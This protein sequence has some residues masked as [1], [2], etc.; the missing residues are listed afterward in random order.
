MRWNEEHSLAGLPASSFI[1]RT[2]CSQR[3]APNEAPMASMARHMTVL[4]CANAQEEEEEEESVNLTE[5][6]DLSSRASREDVLRLYPKA[7]AVNLSANQLGALA[8]VPASLCVLCLSYN[9]FASLADLSSL[10]NLIELDVSHNRL[11]SFG[12]H[13]HKCRSLRILRAGF[14]RI[15][16]VQLEPLEGLLELCLEAN[17]VANFCDLRSLSFNIRLQNLTIRGNP[18]AQKRCMRQRLIDMIPSLVVLDSK[19]TAPSPNICRH[20]KSAEQQA[21]YSDL[22]GL[23]RICRTPGKSIAL[24]SKFQRGVPNKSMRSEKRGDVR[25]GEKKGRRRRGGKKRGGKEKEQENGKQPL[26]VND[27][28]KTLD[29]YTKTYKAKRESHPGLF[30]DFHATK[31]ITQDDYILPSEGSK[32]VEQKILSSY[33]EQEV[34]QPECWTSPSAMADADAEAASREAEDVSNEVFGSRRSTT[35]EERYGRSTA[36]SPKLQCAETV[37]AK[38]DSVIRNEI[39]ALI[40]KRKSSLDRL[41]KDL[42]TYETL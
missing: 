17:R 41:R 36:K 27:I 2:Y 26:Q 30:V 29:A 12:N 15:K 37:H 4:R 19:K 3:V 23:S 38:L 24:S 18:V 7:K 8:F 25:G 21:H 22:H 28:A 40:Q 42:A 13:L 9:K 39:R 32:V 11:K 33:M 6:V 16:V 20:K 35:D 14:N 5:E 1:S 34:K 31:E 10:V